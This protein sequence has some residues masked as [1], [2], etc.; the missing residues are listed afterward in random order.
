MDALPDGRLRSIHRITMKA[1]LI[2]IFRRMQALQLETQQV[3][4]TIPARVVVDPMPDL[5][6]SGYLCR[7]I[8][9]ICE[10]LRKSCNSREDTIGRCIA[11]RAGADSMRGEVTV[12]HGEYAN[13]TP[14]VKVKPRFPDPDTPEY[15]VLM[16]WIG[17]S[18]EMIEKGMLRPS[19]TRIQEILTERA[20]KGEQA[21]PGISVTFTEAN[22]VFRKRR[23]DK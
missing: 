7:E 15:A 10:D 18:D 20:E 5:V 13:A 8:S 14:Y 6:D 1:E 9:N 16:R 17:L 23:N 3:L 21:L 12:L 4:S 19:F 2:K 11:A 22:V